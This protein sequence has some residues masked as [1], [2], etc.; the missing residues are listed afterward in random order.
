MR[1]V[2]YSKI[3]NEEYKVNKLLRKSMIL[4]INMLNVYSQCQKRK[5]NIWRLRSSL[6]IHI[7]INKGERYM[8]L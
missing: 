8:W 4:V 7:Y 3:I 6:K 1:F 5:K 2:P